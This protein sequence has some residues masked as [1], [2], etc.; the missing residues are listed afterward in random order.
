M[1]VF[2]SFMRN[3]TSITEGCE[4]KYDKHELC[5]L[6]CAPLP[7]IDGNIGNTNEE[8]TEFNADAHV[9]YFTKMKGV[10]KKLDVHL[11]M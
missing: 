4:L 10:N 8:S 2:A 5:L 6:A 1:A 11:T 9:N 3:C 7:P